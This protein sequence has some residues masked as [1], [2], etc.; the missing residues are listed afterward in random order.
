MRET[1]AQDG[2]KFDVEGDED[3]NDDEVKDL[4]RVAEGTNPIEARPMTESHSDTISTPNR[5]SED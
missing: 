3:Q 1:E 5:D 4:Y 2:L